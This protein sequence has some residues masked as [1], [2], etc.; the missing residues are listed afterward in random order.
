MGYLPIKEPEEHVVYAIS[1][2]ARQEPKLLNHLLEIFQESSDEVIYN[3]LAK[4]LSNRI[5]YFLLKIISRKNRSRT[6]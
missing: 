2:M 3:A 1:T 6:G 4:V 5:E